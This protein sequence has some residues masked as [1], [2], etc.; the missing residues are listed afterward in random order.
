MSASLGRYRQLTRNLALAATAITVLLSGLAQMEVLRFLEPAQIPMV[1]ASGVCLA[2]YYLV[3]SL[4]APAKGSGRQIA[5]TEGAGEGLLQRSTLR[6]LHREGGVEVGGELET[7]FHRGEKA[8]AACNFAE[9]IEHYQASLDVQP[10]LAA[11]LNLG[12]SL[13]N[14]SSFD[15]ADEVLGI[16]LLMAERSGNRDFQAAF[17]ANLSIVYLHRGRLDEAM[18][19]GEAALDL[20]RRVGD[21]RGQAD[22]ML[23]IGTIRA[24][25]GDREAARKDF[26]AALKRHEIGGSEVGKANA[27]G[28]L[29]NMHMQDDELEEALDHHRRA[30]A[31]H[32]KI[33]NPLGRANALS[34]IGNVRLRQS[35][36]DEALRAYEGALKVYEEISSPLGQA[37]ALGNIGNVQFKQGKTEEAL[38]RYERTLEIHSQIGNALGKA[39]TLTNMGSLFYRTKR[40]QEALEVLNQAR[41][42]FEEAGAQSKGSKALEE[43]LKRV[44]AR[45]GKGGEEEEAEA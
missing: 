2:G 8:Y 26:E 24:N 42:I 7:A 25:Q 39:N 35:E 37:S 45:A 15:Q 18:T 36:P 4:S 32:E 10:T 43:L 23:T 6:G 9:A 28:N 41:R 22:V 30:L 29:G 34:N 31:T 17:S 20:F 40:T 33:G 27:L 1:V 5:S 12:D 13:M 44:T 38:E 21:S 14:S 16:G 3:R 11:Y 19:S